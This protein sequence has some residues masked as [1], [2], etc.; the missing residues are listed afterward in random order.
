MTL[1]VAVIGVLAAMALA[2]DATAA[3]LALYD[4]FMAPQINPEKWYG[5]EGFNSSLN[6]NAEANRF[7]GGEKLHVVLTTYGDVTSDS[8]DRTGRFGLRFA[9]PGLLTAIEV[10]IAVEQAE[11][12]DCTD[13][14]SA[15]RAQAQLLV[16]LFNDG[17]STSSSD[18]TGNIRTSLN[19]QFSGDG[20]QIV[21]SL[22]RC[23][24]SGCISTS[25]LGSF[26]FTTTWT[27]SR[28]DRLRIEW[29]PAGSSVRY[30]VNPETSREEAT[31]LSYTVPN[32]GPP[33][34]DVAQLRNSN[35]GV[36]CMSGRTRVFMDALYDNV[37][38]NPEALP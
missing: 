21:A 38:L 32:D 10:R 2:S 9:N 14:P 29:D 34:S 24:D 3:S 12:D 37:Q 8:D 11:A 6:P 1:G 20:N 25:S 26:T 4:D 16:S 30:T 22:S 5:F 18:R 23:S 15:S 27:L 36:N 33:V 35:T 7:I 13:N 17:S 28:V 31:V 19:K